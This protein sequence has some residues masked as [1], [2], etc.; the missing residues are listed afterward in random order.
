ML[1]ELDGCEPHEEDTWDGRRFAVG[2]AVLR[3][4]GPVARCAMTTRDPETGERNL[5]TLRLIKDYR[6]QLDGR[7]DPVRRL[8]AGR[9]AGAGRGRRRARASSDR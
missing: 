7:R 4:G 2:G 9:A 5:D 1:F 8:R 3:V 6:G